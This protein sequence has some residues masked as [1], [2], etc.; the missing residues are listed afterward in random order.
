VPLEIYRRLLDRYG[1][2]HWWPADDPF[3][4]IVGAILTQSAAWA[5]VEQAL[6]QLKAA[7]PLTPAALRNLPLDRLATLIRPCGYYNAKAVKLRAFVERLGSR[8]DDNLDQLFAL[9]SVDLRQE[10]LSIHG[11]GEETADSI[12][13]YAA[14]KPVFVIDAYTRRI[15]GRLGLTPESDSYSAFQRLFAENL[16]HEEGLFN[17]YHALLV[18]H[19]KEVCRK[20][21]RCPLCC[22]RSICPY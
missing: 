9:E 7:I 21:P 15:M 22:L 14:K 20:S 2:Q 12:I 4:V 5:N 10:L 19:A 1:P 17:E 6:S 16:P 11:I 13:L 18:R 3:E 8:H